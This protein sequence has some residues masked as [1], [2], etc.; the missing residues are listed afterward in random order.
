MIGSDFQMRK[1]KLLSQRTD[2]NGTIHQVVETNCNRCGGAGGHEV[3]KFTGYKCYKCGGS[4]RMIDTNKIYTPEHEEKLR[5]RREKRH[6]K[7][8]EEI[9]AKASE[10]NKEKL[11]EW[12]Y[13][14]EF[15]YMVLGDTFPIREDLKEKGAFYISLLGWYFAEKPSDYQTAEIMVSRLIWFNDLGE[16]YRKDDEEIIQ[17]IKNVRLENEYQSQYVG[18][19]GERIEIELNFIAGFWLESYN[20]YGSPCINKMKDQQGNI[21]IWKTG[22][23]LRHDVNEEGKVKLKATIKE[24]SDFR[25]EKQTILTRCKVL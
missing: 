10:R 14:K 5:I 19:V 15:I 9:K 24:H 18:E 21:F 6:Q 20:H 8:I 22:R 23:N 4:G 3:W 7:K 13:D 11:V 1:D 25:E 17:F 12:G 2:K 16:V